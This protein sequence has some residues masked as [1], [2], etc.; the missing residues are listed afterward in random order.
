MTERNP[1]DDRSLSVR[2][3]NVLCFL[4]IDSESKLDVVLCSG[5]LHKQRNIGPKSIAEAAAWLKA[6]S[7]GSM[8]DGA[9]LH[10]DVDERGGKRWVGVAA[11]Q[12]KML[13]PMA[14]E[15]ALVFIPSSWPIGT[16]R[17]DAARLAEALREAQRAFNT[18]GVM[19]VKRNAELTVNA[20]LAAHDAGGKGGA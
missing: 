10:L 18:Y 13:P 8:E 2:L 19:D 12:D 11:G 17:A 6:Q 1:Q 7:Y 20:A 4:G 16:T 5:L 14:V 15:Q 9:V 3:R